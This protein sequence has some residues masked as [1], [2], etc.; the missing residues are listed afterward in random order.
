M[1]AAF[2]EVTRKGKTLSQNQIDHFNEHG[3]I[4]LPG[5]LNQDEIDKIQGIKSRSEARAVEKGGSFLEG[6]AHYELESVANPDGVQTM[7]LRKVQEVF[8]AE[9]KFKSVMAS[10]KI[11]DVVE[12]LI[13]SNIYYHSSKLMCKPANGGRRKPWHQDFAYWADMNT[14]QVTVWTAIDAATLENGCMQVMPGSHKRGLV[15]HHQGE[16]WMIDESNIPNENVVYAE[17]KP[18]DTLIFNVLTLHASD[19]NHSPEP[20]LSAIIDFDSQPKP[21]EHSD[22]GSSEP[23]R[24]KKA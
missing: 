18:G 16:D 15:G 10:D 3:Y 4:I 1:T 24:E 13:G 6:K 9:E 19:P 20:R 22:Y 7:V 14:K 2:E 12:D 8:L 5:F 11:L 17:M 23:L 21:A